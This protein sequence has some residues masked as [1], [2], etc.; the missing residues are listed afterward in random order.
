MKSFRFEMG[1][2]LLPLI[3]LTSCVED[4]IR[5]DEKV[6]LVFS[7]ALKENKDGRTIDA[8]I[9]PGASALISVE[10]SNGELVVDQQEVALQK[11]ADGY[12]TAP[13]RLPQ[14][15]YRLVDFM[16]VDE[17]GEILYATPRQGSVLSQKSPLSLPYNLVISSNEIFDN[18]IAVIDTQTKTAKDF[19]Y[20][21]FRR[22]A[23]S[24]KL[25]VYIAKDKKLVNTSAEALIMKGLDT[26]MTY[27]LSANMNSIAFT[28][29]PAET[30][31]LVVV[32]DSYSRFAQ[33]FS[34]QN[35]NGKPLKVVLEP[36][37]TVV[38]V[39]IAD[40]N[41]FGMQLDPAWDIF[42]FQVDWGDGSNETWTSGVTTIVEHFYDQPG[43]YFISI[44]G[45]GL[46]SVVLVGNL[47]GG[48]DIAR[49]GME[50][51]VNLLD[52]RIE[53]GVGPKVIDLSHNKL[54]NEIRIY[55]HPLG[56][57]SPLEDLIIP[58]DA[59]IYNMEI[60]GNTNM[61]PESFNELVNDL[62]HQVVNRPR[63]GDFWFSTWEDNNVPMVTPSPE[64][65]EKIRDLKNTY[66]WF[67][68]PDP[69]LL[70]E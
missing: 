39:P 32:K 26:L 65:L 41:Y 36:A 46:D 29:D 58:N 60:G 10:M 17:A 50:H 20:D 57:V 8:Q 62:H 63:S 64:A 51:L 30:Y 12:V 18:K 52:F 6:N 70:P 38:G 23:R 34:P 59:F 13:L 66:N 9:S 37:L 15:R 19:G 47:V 40:Q 35:I 21:S 44:T 2:L 67:V 5:D 22:Q 7:V 56:P 14:G 4:E 61:K 25:Q 54:L 42:D 33:N 45:H 1:M 53:Y 11:D 55:S 48:G 28:G 68:N 69:D 3:L 43:H 49:L 27:Q 16:V 31:T 24:I